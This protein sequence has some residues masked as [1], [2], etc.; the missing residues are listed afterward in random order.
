MSGTG[1]YVVNYDESVSRPFYVYTGFNADTYFEGRNFTMGQSGDITLSAGPAT[2]SP[3]SANFITIG[4]QGN[5]TIASGLHLV[6]GSLTGTEIDDDGAGS[7]GIQLNSANYLGPGGPIELSN[8]TGGQSFDTQG[9]FS[10]ED[11]GSVGW[12][13]DTNGTGNFSADTIAISTTTAAKFTANGSEVCTTANGACSVA[14][15]SFGTLAGGTNNAAAMLVG[16]GASLGPTG[17]G[18]ITATV[19]ADLAGGALGSFPYQSAANTTAFVASPTT[20]GH[21]FVPTW[22]PT[23]SAIALA[24][25]D[26]GNYLGTNVT[27]ASPIV[28]TPSTLGVQF[29]CPSCGS[30]SGGTAVTANGGGALASLN[31]NAISPVA[32]AS[33]LALLPKISGASM[34]IEAPYATSSAFGVLEGDGS[35]TTITAGVIKCTTSTTSQ[36]GCVKPDGT[37][38]TISGGVISAFGGNFAS[39]LGGTNTSAAMVVGT[40]A[41]LGVSGSGTIAATSAPYSGLT[42][43]VP[44]WNQNTTGNAA[45]ATLAS[46]LLWSS[47]LAPTSNLALTMAAH[48]STFTYNA[49]TGSSDLFKLTDTASNT[50]TGILLHVATASGSTETPWQADANGIGCKINSAGQLQCFGGTHMLDL[51]PNSGGVPSCAASSWLH[52][53]GR[54][55]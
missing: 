26:L 45:T 36:L 40:G 2:D 32:D 47:L 11:V 6:T 28:A 10:W 44:T 55:R 39:L 22:S 48:T 19:T 34:I 54:F 41:S 3:S 38:V 49:A 24:S 4:A 15:P 30:S 35:T 51:G 21:V 5:I 1:G 23:G 27:A 50:G 53:Y 31:I 7:F 33:Y 42:G 46:S 43:S 17:S 29:S 9:G 16:T 13:M 18:I 52:R 25:T 37:T 14:T 20:S 12:S 8:H